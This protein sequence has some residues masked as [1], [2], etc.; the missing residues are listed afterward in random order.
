MVNKTIA[1]NLETLV[2]ESTLDWKQ[3]LFRFMFLYNTSF[4]ESTN[5][6]PFCITFGVHPQIPKELTKPQYGSKPTTNS[7]LQ[8]QL[9]IHFANLPESAESNQYKHQIDY[10]TLH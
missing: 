6:A 2:D 3:F 8:L 5:M 10:H 1:H 4:H 7:L 9:A